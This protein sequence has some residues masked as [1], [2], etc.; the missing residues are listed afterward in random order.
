MFNYKKQIAILFSAV[1]ALSATA[2]SN[3]ENEEERDKKEET[4]SISLSEQTPAVTEVPNSDIS[5]SDPSD[6]PATTAVSTDKDGMMLVSLI[7]DVPINETVFNDSG[8]TVALDRFSVEEVPE[9]KT[10]EGS[11]KMN[12]QNT[13]DRSIDVDVSNYS[14]ND[15]AINDAYVQN[16]SYAAHSDVGGSASVFFGYMIEET[17]YNYNDI[18]YISFDLTVKDSMSGDVIGKSVHYTINFQ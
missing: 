4:I 7:D 13:T 3:K 8:I 5:E 14:V 16:R 12:V 9:Y 2:C 1:I 18:R 11:I 15:T 17:G 10:Y 6:P